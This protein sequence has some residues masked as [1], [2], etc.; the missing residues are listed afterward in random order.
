MTYKTY[1][2]LCTIQFFAT[3]GIMAALL[4]GLLAHWGPK[5]YAGVVIAAIVN[6]AA[7]LILRRVYCHYNQSD[8]M[9]KD[10]I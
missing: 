10:T 9:C 8:F 4:I 5:F 3:I 6:M 1:Y 7:R 2:T